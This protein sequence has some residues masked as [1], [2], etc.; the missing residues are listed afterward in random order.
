VLDLVRGTNSRLT[1]GLKNHDYPVWSRDGQQIAFSFDRDPLWVVH[2]MSANEAGKEELVAE[3]DR[4]EVVSQWT[5]DGQY[6]MMSA[7][8]F[9][10]SP[11]EIWAAPSHVQVSLRL[12]EL[13]ER[14]LPPN[15]TT[16]LAAES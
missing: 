8:S 7:V 3:L 5:R 10:K 4:S 16:W 11:V 1:S 13:P 9:G 15:N 12:G 14:T 2:R 6:L